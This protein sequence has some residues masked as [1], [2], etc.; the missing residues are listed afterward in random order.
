MSDVSP[1]TTL[2]PRRCLAVAVPCFNEADT[3]AALVERV[4]AAPWTAEIVVVDDGSTDGTDKVLADL[5]TEVDDPRL[6]VVTH[7]RNRGKGAALRSAFAVVTAD[8]VVIQDA[9]L[10][11]DPRDYDGAPRTA[12]TGARRCR[13]RISLPQRATASGPVLLAFP[14][15]PGAHAAVE[16]VHRPQLDRH[17]VVLQVL[18]ARGAGQHHAAR[19]PI[20][21]R[22]RAHRQG[23]RRRVAD[24][25]GRDLLQRTDLRRRQ[26]DQLA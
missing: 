14:R 2:A 1:G 16:H 9:D 19:G 5:V 11:Y 23:R 7:E 22:A 3:V 13:V 17:G 18:P 4:L 25:R 6:T 10:E 8:Y 21:D 12:R 24:L 15:Q 26:E 20:R